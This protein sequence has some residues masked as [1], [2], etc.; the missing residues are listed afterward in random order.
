MLEQRTRAQNESN[1]NMKTC[2]CFRYVGYRRSLNK[3]CFG[4]VVVVVV[5]LDSFKAGARQLA[6]LCLSYHNYNYTVLAYSNPCRRRLSSAV[7]RIIYPRIGSII[8]II[9]SLSF[10]FSLFSV[11]V[12]IPQISGLN[13]ITKEK[14]ARLVL[15]SFVS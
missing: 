12:L 10:S 14:R 2:I 7:F 11:N 13:R 3:H 5:I 6:S 9:I 8:V 1:G 15:Q 4:G